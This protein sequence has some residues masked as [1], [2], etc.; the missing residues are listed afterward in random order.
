LDI[1]KVVFSLKINCALNDSAK[2]ESQL[3]A[4]NAIINAY[5]LKLSEYNA[6]VA[7]AKALQ[8][9]KIRTNPGFYRQ[10]ENMVLRK[11]CISYIID[12]NQTAKR[13]YGKSMTNGKNTFGTYEVKVDDKLDDYA[14]FAKFIEQAFEWEIMS[15]NFYPYYWGDRKSWA[16]LYQY[17]NNDPLFRNFMQA[18]MARAIVTVRPGFEEAVSYYMQTGQIWNGGEVPVIEDKLF[19]SI[20]DEL[21]QPKGQKEGK[22]WAT[23]LPTALTILQADSI[24]LKV[25]Q[26]LPYNEDLSDFEDPTQVPQSPNFH[27]NETPM[28]GNPKTIEFTFQDLDSGVLKTIGEYDLASYFPREYECMGQKITINRDAKW[29][30]NT[31]STVIFEELADQLSLLTGINARISAS[32]IGTTDGITFTVD[33]SKIKDFNFK[34]PGDDPMIDT[35]R[36]IIEDNSMVKIG[37]S[38]YNVGRIQDKSGVALDLSKP[39]NLF[40]ISRFEV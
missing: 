27:I 8:T 13:T 18:G 6:K 35:L 33:V 17:D 25:E 38:G 3:E 32:N 30:A 10:I 26:A 7:Q 37:Q 40:P 39:I 14:A 19:M 15:Y 29:Q 1:G 9:E 31:G 34:K 11:N 12:Q 5:E 36:V 23:R 16:Q 4:Y 20:V 21:R 24:G 2:K 28:N 22:A